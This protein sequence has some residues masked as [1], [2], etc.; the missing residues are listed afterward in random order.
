VARLSTRELQVF[1]LAGEGV[2]TREIAEILCISPRSV[3]SH[4]EHNEGK[5][6]MGTAA[7]LAAHAAQ[8]LQVSGQGAVRFLSPGIQIRQA[9]F[10]SPDR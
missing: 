5:L 4:N 3:D 8:W 10:F 9:D 1:R 2:P 6:G 7:E